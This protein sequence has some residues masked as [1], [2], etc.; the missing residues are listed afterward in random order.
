MNP[1]TICCSTSM[2]NG[3]GTP[4]RLTFETRRDSTQTLDALHDASRA[5]WA[6]SPDLDLLA[7]WV[8]PK[9]VRDDAAEM[10]R[11]RALTP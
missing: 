4:G 2:I 6:A 1:R 3:V 7:V 8:N 10:R 9:L 11:L 5:A